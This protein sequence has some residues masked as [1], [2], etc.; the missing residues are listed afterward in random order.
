MASTSRIEINGAINTSDTVLN[1]ISKIAASCQAFV[2][3]DPSLGQWETII[4][5]TGSSV[6]TFDDSNIIGAIN[7][8]GSGINNIYNSVRVQYRSKDQRG[9]QDERVLSIDSSERFA[10]ELDNQLSLNFDFITDPVQAELLGAIELKQSRVDKIIEFATDFR[11]LG[12]RAGDLFGV[13]NEVYFDRS[14]VNPKLFRAISIEETDSEDGGII[15]QITGIEYD[16]SVYSTSG[17]TR[18]ERILD[19]GIPPIRANQCVILKEKIATGNA[20][21]EALQTDAGR[22]AITGAGVPI[23]ATLSLQ[24]DASYIESVFE[25]AYDNNYYFFNKE[26]HLYPGSS[27]GDGLYDPLSAPYYYAWTFQTNNTIKTLQMDF[28]GAQATMNYTVDGATKQITAGVPCKI[29]LFYAQSLSGPFLHQDSRF[30]EWSSYISSMSISSINVAPVVWLFMVTPLNT[31]DLNASNN[32]VLPQDFLG[33]NAGVLADE[34]GDAS[35][36]TVSLFLN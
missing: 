11:A 4:N 18:E 7:V 1:N 2:T 6:M 12:L 24:E 30:L 22:L 17:L 27:P 36:L 34:Q 14:S 31:Y 28:A 25:S 16:S 19:S 20:I 5:T 21:G 29:D 3:W 26:S 15:L 23:F 13:K 8:S 35:Y 32:N 9:K 10:Q 33:A